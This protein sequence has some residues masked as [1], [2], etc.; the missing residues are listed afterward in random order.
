M[1]DYTYSPSTL[2]RIRSTVKFFQQT[3]S[4]PT[5]TQN[6]ATPWPNQTH[7]VRNLPTITTNEHIV[8][9]TNSSLYQPSQP[10]V[11]VADYCHNRGTPTEPQSLR[12]G[13][14]WLLLCVECPFQLRHWVPSY[15]P[16]LLLRAHFSYDIRNYVPF[17]VP[18]NKRKRDIP[19][20]YARMATRNNLKN[21]A[22]YVIRMI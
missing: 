19:T 17:F 4:N 5:T 12:S 18:P 9:V 10:K 20:L 22:M 21:E 13:G 15:L 11:V 1:A 8:C 14:L 7:S 6:C 16:I 2:G 3:I